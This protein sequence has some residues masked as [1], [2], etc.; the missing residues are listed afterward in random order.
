[1]NR[2]KAINSIFLILILALFIYS[3]ESE[4]VV[5]DSSITDNNTFF[6][7]QFFSMS[8]ES[9]STQYL[10]SSVGESQRL[11][12]GLSDEISKTTLLKLDFDLLRESKYCLIDPNAGI[13]DTIINELDSIR[14]VLRSFTKLL[15]DNEEL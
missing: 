5:I 3:C 15:D 11:Y 10:D 12:S 7:S 14:L 13:A 8:G 1:M 4:P 2:N 9:A 6:I